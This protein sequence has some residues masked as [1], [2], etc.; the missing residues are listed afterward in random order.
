[1]KR[2]VVIILFLISICSYGQFE[3]HQFELD[4]LVYFYTLDAD[5]INGNYIENDSATGYIKQY[6]KLIYK[7]KALKPLIPI[8]SIQYD[9]DIQIDRMYF[10]ELHNGEKVGKWIKWNFGG[11]TY[12]REQSIY[13]L[14]VIE[15][16]NDTIVF[17][18]GLIWPFNKKI[19]YVGDSSEVYGQT[20]TESD[21]L[22][23]FKCENKRTCKYWLIE[24]KQIIDSSIYAD[25]HFKLGQFEF[26][27]Y[28]R[29]IK[30]MIKE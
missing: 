24:P 6:R 23:E 17:E 16:K 9:Y 29:K 2:T 11:T 25:L 26:G 21:Y 13:E 10:G 18:N 5:T 1:M 15:Y 3:S 19:T 28:D 27:E 12:C 30:K 14:Y 8:D 22:I 4:T 20:S 7:R